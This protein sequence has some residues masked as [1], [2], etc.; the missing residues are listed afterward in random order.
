MLISEIGAL[1][2]KCGWGIMG[3]KIKGEGVQL[4]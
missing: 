2:V 4:F 1:R 3:G